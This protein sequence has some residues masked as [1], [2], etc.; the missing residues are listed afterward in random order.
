MG[1]AAFL[2]GATGFI[3]RALARQ[4]AAQ[5][6][7]AHRDPR[8]G[9]NL[10]YLQGLPID[11]RAGDLTDPAPLRTALPAADAAQVDGGGVALSVVPAP[12]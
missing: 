10:R 12:K 7:V 4:L 8:P 11:W 1:Q 2:T 5:G 9:S 6:P 3:G